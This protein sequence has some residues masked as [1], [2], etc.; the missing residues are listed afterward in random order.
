[1]PTTSCCKHE[2]FNYR[3]LQSYLASGILADP[4]ELLIPLGMN[5]VIQAPQSAELQDL[6]V[7]SIFAS[8]R[9]YIPALSFDG[10]NEFSS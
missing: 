5:G 7:Y 4:K 3:F 9:S 2:V 1:M 6:F 10:E 8:S